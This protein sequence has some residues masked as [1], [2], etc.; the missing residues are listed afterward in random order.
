[1][2]VL[3]VGKISNSD[4]PFQKHA[5]LEEITRKYPRTLYI[6]E[7]DAPPAKLTRERIEEIYRDLLDIDKPPYNNHSP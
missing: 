7:L 4:S 1:M 2:K 3:Y 6:T 5:V